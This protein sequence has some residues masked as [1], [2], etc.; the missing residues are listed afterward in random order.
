MYVYHHY[1]INDTLLYIEFLY[2]LLIMISTEQFCGTCYIDLYSPLRQKTH[3][4]TTL[5]FK[6]M[7]RVILLIRFCKLLSTVAILSGIARVSSALMARRPSMGPLF[8]TK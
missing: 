3:K 2:A 7:H 6:V 4:H 8:E 1:L 5:A